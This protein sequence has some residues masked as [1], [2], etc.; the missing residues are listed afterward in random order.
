M[1]ITY[2]I[3]AGL[4]VDRYHFLWDFLFMT[5]KGVK[6]EVLQDADGLES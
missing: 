3:E 5:Q 4:T 1:E 6:S 2:F